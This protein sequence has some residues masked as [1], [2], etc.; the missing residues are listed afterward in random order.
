MSVHLGMHWGMI[1]GVV[2]KMTKMAEGFPLSRCRKFILRTAGVSVA[3]YGACA[4]AKREVPQ[5][6]AFS[7]AFD[8]W[9]NGQL[10][11]LFFIDFLSIMGL[12]VWTAHYIRKG[13]QSLQGGGI[14]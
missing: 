10:P 7:Y 1:M 4:F 5:K 2:G 3:L 13:V 12:F 9:D 8:F 6:L 14:S 11:V